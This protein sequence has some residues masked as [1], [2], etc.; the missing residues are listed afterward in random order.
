ML[1]ITVIALQLLHHIRKITFYLWKHLCYFMLISS[2]AYKVSFFL[3]VLSEH[4]FEGKIRYFFK[5]LSFEI[6]N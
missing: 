2:F 4:V 5:E 3:L 6:Q 1:T